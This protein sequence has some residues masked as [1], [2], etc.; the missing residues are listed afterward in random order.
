MKS[1]YSSFDRLTFWL[2]GTDQDAI[3]TGCL[4]D[5]DMSEQKN[6]GYAVAIS[7]VIAFSVSQLLFLLVMK[8]LNKPE[9]YAYFLAFVWAAFVCYTDRMLFKKS[10]AQLYFRVGML[11]FNAVVMSIGYQVYESDTQIEQHIKNESGAVNKDVYEQR[12]IKRKV[13][14]DKIEELQEQIKE[15]WND[16]AIRYKTRTVKAV[17]EL[18]DQKKTDLAKFDDEQKKIIENLIHEPDL[19]FSKKTKV[20]WESFLFKSFFG[21]LISLLVI[22]F[23]GLPLGMRLANYQSDY[24]AFMEKK[25]HIPM[26][27][28]RTLKPSQ[29]VQVYLQ[30]Q[31]ENQIRNDEADNEDATGSTNDK[32]KPDEDLFPPFT[33]KN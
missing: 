15:I 24:L 14:T 18:V 7:T 31:K 25:S 28:W 22:A 33:F 29:K 1:P 20:F 16:P 12:D 21:V 5:N 8:G 6:F 11:V 2:A 9:S 30:V 3:K 4:S 23:E 32:D 13:F 19:S 26:G 10:G 17:Q 27:Q